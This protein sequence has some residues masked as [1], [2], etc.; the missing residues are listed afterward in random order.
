VTQAKALCNKFINEGHES[1]IVVFQTSRGVMLG[2][3]LGGRWKLLLI[4]LVLRLVLV[5]VKAS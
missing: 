5:V 1:V 4:F 3:I 2:E